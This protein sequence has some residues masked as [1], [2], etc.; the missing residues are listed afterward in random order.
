MPTNRDMWRIA[1]PMILSNISIPLLGVVDTAVM[2]HLDSPTYLGA[3]AI[4]G[5]IF[6]FLY[7]GMNF[8]RMGTTG[9]AAQRFGA[10]DFDSLRVELGQ[11]V[12]V[13]LAIA[14]TI[15]VLQVPIGTFGL[16]LLGGDAET[17]AHAATYFSIRVWSAP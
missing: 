5:A 12:I 14:L 4:G 7:S 16:F 2:G 6:S 15:L 1:A 10:A 11:A 9:I 13:R 17:Q 3:V 8:L